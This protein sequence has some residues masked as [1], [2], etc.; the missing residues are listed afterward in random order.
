VSWSPP[1]FD[2]PIVIGGQT[3][4]ILDWNYTAESDGLLLIRL[5]ILPIST[6]PT[7]NVATPVPTPEPAPARKLFL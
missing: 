2:E 5:T 6:H 4:G 7:V 3:Y 1:G